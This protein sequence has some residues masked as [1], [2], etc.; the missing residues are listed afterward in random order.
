MIVEL[1]AL[2]EVANF[3]L[4]VFGGVIGLSVLRSFRGGAMS[5]AIVWLLA[6]GGVFAVHEL[7]S[8]LFK[9]IWP[10]PWFEA[11]YSLSETAF[12]ILLIIGVY[13]LARVIPRGV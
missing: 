6:A 5:S 12:I 10:Q 7:V 8:I 4:I 1:E 3:I 9:W 13:K 2:I 11:A